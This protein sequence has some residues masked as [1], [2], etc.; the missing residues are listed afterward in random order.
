MRNYFF[1]QVILLRIVVIKRLFLLLLFS[2]SFLIISSCS[3][4]PVKKVTIHD[5]EQLRISGLYNFEYTPE[6]IVNQLNKEGE[7]VFECSTKQRKIP[8]YI[9]ILAVSDGLKVN[10]YTRD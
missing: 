5:F 10:A 8:C 3:L 9:K 6:E 2:S 7:A 1:T 4:P